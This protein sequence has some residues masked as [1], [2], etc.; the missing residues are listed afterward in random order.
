VGLPAKLGVLGRLAIWDADT[1]NDANLKK[2]QV[3]A[4]LGWNPHSLFQVAASGLVTW[5]DDAEGTPETEA[6]IRFLLSSEFRF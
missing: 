3:L 4:G 2:Y 6:N 5:Y 1:D